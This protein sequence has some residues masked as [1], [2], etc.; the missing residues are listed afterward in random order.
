MNQAESL[1][2]ILLL[3]LLKAFFCKVFDIKDY[4][5]MPKVL[6]FLSLTLK[7]KCKAYELMKKNIDII[8][9]ILKRTS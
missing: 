4:F 7:A 8:N 9:N 1:F 6:V 3:I 5:I 2:N